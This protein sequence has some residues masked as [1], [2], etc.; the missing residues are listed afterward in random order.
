MAEP[1]QRTIL[2]ENTENRIHC[3]ADLP[4]RVMLPVEK[5]TLGAPEPT[6]DAL[7]P[8]INE[9]DEKAWAE[10]EKHPGVQYLIK[11]GVFKVRR[12]SAEIAS[13]APK[14]AVELI[15]ATIDQGLLEKW[16]EQE[17]RKQ[18]LDAILAQLDT[19]KLPPQKDR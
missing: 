4:L 2:V 17:K 6:R 1:V 16:F 19:I 15:R 3:V 13:L 14:D 11:S 5:R 12:T 8:G 9:V 10:A 7:Y 18:V